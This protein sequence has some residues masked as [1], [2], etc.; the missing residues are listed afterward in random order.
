MNL[1]KQKKNQEICENRKKF[2]KRNRRIKIQNERHQKG[3]I[4]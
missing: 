2:W 1:K 3:E 4:K